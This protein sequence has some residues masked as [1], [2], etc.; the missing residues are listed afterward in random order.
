M[1]WREV[2]LLAC[3][4]VRI[5][6]SLPW[7][8][9]NF[10]PCIVMPILPKQGAY[11]PIYCYEHFL[12][13]SLSGSFKTYIEGLVWKYRKAEYVQRRVPVPSSNVQVLFVFEVV[14]IVVF[15]QRV[16]SIKGCL[17]S[18]LVKGCLPSK[19]I[20][21]QRSSSI[22][23]RLPSKVVFHRRSSS[24]EG[25]LPSKVVFNRRSSSTPVL[26]PRYFRSEWSKMSLV[27]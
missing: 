13:G 7:S 4:E 5:L 19:V 6:S 11:I 26:P 27:V 12:G 20:F 15:H 25:C 9:G 24:I 3:S 23:G 21:H 8:G 2:S 22:E 16:S 17:Q 14:L 10:N 1:L 18:K